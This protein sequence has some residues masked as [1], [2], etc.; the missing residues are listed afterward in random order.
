MQSLQLGVSNS[1]SPH[2]GKLPGNS[3][4]SAWPPQCVIILSVAA[5]VSATS[6]FPC[7][8]S[9][10]KKIK[11]IKKK[12]PTHGQPKVAFPQ[13]MH[14]RKPNMYMIHEHTFSPEFSDVEKTKI[15]DGIKL[16]ETNM[17]PKY[18]YSKFDRSRTE[19]NLAKGVTKI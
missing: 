18:H 13:N 8:T 17:Q 1:L 15:M 12:I 9:G 6:P 5:A 14:C 16:I 2:P 19:M 10:K 4:F 11:N 7:C 3:Q